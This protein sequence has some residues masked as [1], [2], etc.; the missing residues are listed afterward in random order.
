MDRIADNR[1]FMKSVFGL[2]P[3]GQ[4]DQSRGL[5]QPPLELPADPAAPLV[6]LPKP[7][8]R[9]LRQA[10]IHECLRHRRSRR[11]W[12]DEALS[13][14]ELSFLLWAT[15]GVEEVLGGGY[16]TL[17]PA[18]SAGARHPFETYL[19]VQRVA[20]VK[21]GVYRY[22]PLTHTLTL[23]FEDRHMRRGLLEATFEQRFVADAPVTFIWSCVPYRGEW[24]YAT[25]A[26]K[27]MLLDAGHV[28]Q[29]LYLACEALGAGTCAIGAYN[30]DAMDA[31]LRLDGQD[32][33]VVYLAP[34][35][36]TAPEPGD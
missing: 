35:G 25:A 19:A 8:P 10:D 26:H 16:A 20:G 6:A 18:P 3:P 9:V 5:P 14:E 12:T 32:E 1:R 27:V 36:K 15:Q 34:V 13:L 22:L 11:R 28:C 29:N 33:F 23:V 17:R 7:G 30:Q 21:P 31:F 4:S 2:L 24:R